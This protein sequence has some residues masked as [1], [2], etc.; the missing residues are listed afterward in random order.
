[1]SDSLIVMGVACVTAG[2]TAAAL[3]R[4]PLGF[5]LYL[6]KSSTVSFSSETVS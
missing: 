1:M 5:G 4:L 6:L 3:L 2:D